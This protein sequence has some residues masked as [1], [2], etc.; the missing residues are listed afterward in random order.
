[1]IH[2]TSKSDF[3]AISF[4]TSILNDLK[5]YS[6]DFEISVINPFRFLNGE[7]IDN[8]KYY[9]NLVTQDFDL[10]K[11][12]S[13]QIDESLCKRFTLIH[14]RACVEKSE[15]AD[16]SFIYPNVT[17]YPNSKLKKDVIVQSNSRISHNVTIGDG[18]FIGGLVNISGSVN[19]G[20]FCKIY[21]CCNIID[22]IEV[23]DDVILGTGSTIR[24][25]ITESGTYSEIPSK[26]KKIR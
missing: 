18:C 15:V 23:V 8:S 7:E 16:G 9:I 6:T 11:Q 13:H 26:I 25:N 5:K 19:V 1:M 24:K 10:R 12:V 14:N 2:L 21:P 20:S 17:L 3:I 4:D 22:K